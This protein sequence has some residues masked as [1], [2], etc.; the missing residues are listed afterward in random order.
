MDKSDLTV[1]QLQHAYKLTESQQFIYGAD[2]L[3]TR[4]NTGGSINGANEEDD[5]ISFIHD[6]DIAENESSLDVEINDDNKD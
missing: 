4:P 5:D 2:A 3:F 6:D 1:L